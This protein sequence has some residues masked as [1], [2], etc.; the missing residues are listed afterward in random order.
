MRLWSRKRRL[1]YCLCA[2]AVVA[3]AAAAAGWRP[4]LYCRPGKQPSISVLRQDG[5]IILVS[6]PPFSGV[7]FSMG[8]SCRF[9][10]NQDAPPRRPVKDIAYYTHII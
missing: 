1:V 8:P 2:A 3:A 4:L 5:N 9:A 6:S 10:G 7:G